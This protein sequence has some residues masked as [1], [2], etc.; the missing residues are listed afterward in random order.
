M[1]EPTA[2]ALFRAVT[3]LT[4]FT[5]RWQLPLNP[6]D[7][8]EVAYAVMLHARSDAPPDQIAMTVEQ[9]IDRHE[10]RARALLDAMRVAHG[11]SEQSGTFY[12]PADA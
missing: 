2:A 5:R 1:S 10:E 11:S 6:E 4:P 9:Q 3:A 12:P 7:A 8:E